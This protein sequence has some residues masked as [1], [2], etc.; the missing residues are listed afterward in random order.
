MSCNPKTNS[1]DF[2]K[3]F[4]VASKGMFKIKF[5]PPQF[6]TQITA[7]RTYVHMYRRKRQNMSTSDLHEPSPKYQ[8]ISDEKPVLRYAFMEFYIFGISLYAHWSM[9]FAGLY[10]WWRR[11]R[12]TVGVRIVFHSI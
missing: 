4:S 10:H 1:E 6:K 3:I 12:F 9:V 2:E 5:P 8:I 7:L 11:R